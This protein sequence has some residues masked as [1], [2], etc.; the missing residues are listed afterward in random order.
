MMKKIGWVVLVTGVMGAMVSASA[1]EYGCTVLLCLS[2]TQGP[3]AVAECRPPVDRL[4]RDLHEGRPFP[5][6]DEANQTGQGGNY[7]EPVNDPYDPCPAPLQVADHQAMVV[8]GAPRAPA[9][10]SRFQSTVFDIVGSP[11]PSERT[12]DTGMAGPRACVGESVG[13]YRVGGAEDGYLVTVF[14]QVLWQ[15]AQSPRAIDVF[16]QNKLVQRVRW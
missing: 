1:S 12:T 16:N 4:Y 11:Q 15:P 5:T 6:C 8:Q 2:N 13:S 9:S 7:A 3:K 10:S 14:H